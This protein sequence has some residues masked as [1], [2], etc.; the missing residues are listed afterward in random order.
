MG[1]SPKGPKGGVR[2]WLLVAAI[3]LA[4]V[5]AGTLLARRFARSK[6]EVYPLSNLSVGYWESGELNGMITNGREQTVVFSESKIESIDVQVGQAV[7]PGD[8]LMRYDTTS[9]ELK[10]EKDE[11]AVAMG[12]SELRRAERELA[13]IQSLK[14]SEWAPQPYEETI[15]HGELPLVSSV[16]AGDYQ[17]GVER[18]AFDCT[19][20]AV[21]EAEFLRAL[22]DS[23]GSCELHVYG[24]NEAGDPTYYGRWVV[25]GTSLPTTRDVYVP[26]DDGG[27][28]GGTPGD[29]GG[30]DTAGDLGGAGDSGDTV[31][32]STPD[33]GGAGTPDPDPTPDPGGG[34]GPA[35]EPAPAEERYAR[36]EVEAI[37][38]DWRIADGL[39]LGD[40][41]VE[42]TV[43]LTPGYGTFLSTTPTPYE[44]YETIHIA[45][46]TGDGDDYAYSS[47]ELG[48]MAREQQK[49]IQTAELDLRAARVALEQDRLVGANGEVRSSI[50]GTVTEVADPTALSVGQTLISVRGEESFLVTLYVNELDLSHVNLGDEYLI[51]S[52]ES[53]ASATARVS[54][55]GTTPSETSWASGDTNPNTSWY[56]VTAAIVNDAPEGG[57][58]VSFKVG[59]GCQAMALSGG[60]DESGAIYLEAMFVRRDGEGAYV[61]AVGADGRL[62][63]RPVKTGTV[64]WGYM[65]QV[66]EGLTMEDRIA[67]PYGPDVMAGAR[68]SDADYPTY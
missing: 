52:W 5:V 18:Y 28:A 36:T 40:E 24:P 48:R 15:D 49:A 32:E 39:A 31:G 61:M 56:P 1:G 37:A 35:P 9:F 25:D 8:V 16:G 26:V 23:G 17:P 54:E 19:L 38:E 30:D 13:R 51:T 2:R 63:R 27:G 33:P 62:E 4:C 41:G 50:F 11:A 12:E 68:V 65:V 6:V 55:I 46:D 64:Y 7:N 22:R 66:L 14:P 42:L 3:A 34:D 53:G 67:F 45:P 44:R 57:S 43:G 58:P 10:I 20:D 59:E 29:A 47:E 60:D 21:V